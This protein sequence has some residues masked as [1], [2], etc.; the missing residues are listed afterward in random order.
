MSDLNAMIDDALVRY[1]ETDPGQIAAR[2]LPLLTQEKRREALEY[3]LRERVR[4]RIAA[5][6]SVEFDARHRDE[7]ERTAPERAVKV[8][9]GRA[10]R[11]EVE[12]MTDDEL[13]RDAHLG[14]T[15]WARSLGVG[16]AV[17]ARVARDRGID[18][19]VERHT[20]RDRLAVRI[21]EAMDTV[22]THYRSEGVLIAL[23]EANTERVSVAGE[24]M[25]LGDCTAADLRT[26]ADEYM[27][28]ATGQVDRGAYY[29]SV[30]DTMDSGGYKT[31][32]DMA[33]ASVRTGAAA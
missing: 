21:S 2:L 8:V 17:A 22:A 18:F 33:A 23:Q 12:A 19:D 1:P 4:L 20:Y 30:A 11:A 24:W 28:R 29:L 6:R 5:H 15:R 13:R 7:R 10:R 32:R 3:G 25:M 31:V 27:D 14:I 9:R 26:L 16:Y